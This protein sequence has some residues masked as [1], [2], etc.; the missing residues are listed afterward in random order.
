MNKKIVKN[1]F[2]IKMEEYMKATGKK[3]SIDCNT[4]LLSQEYI[5]S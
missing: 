3:I 4:N 2:K 5:I 1:F